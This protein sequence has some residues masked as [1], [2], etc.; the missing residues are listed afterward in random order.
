M[1]KDKF[2]KMCIY[3]PKTVFNPEVIMASGQVF[4]MFKRNEFYHV[5]S[6]NK[7]IAFKL[8]SKENY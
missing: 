6:G 2:S 1:F 3:L 7:A 8:S 5:Y 4:R